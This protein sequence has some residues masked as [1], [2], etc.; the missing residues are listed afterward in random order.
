MKK[1]R[2]LMLADSRAF[3]TERLVPE[4]RRQGCAAF[5]ASMENGLCHHFHLRRR[6]PLRQL[7][8]RL[9]ARQVQEIIRRWRP[10]IINPHFASGY[11]HLAAVANRTFG[12]PIVLNLWGS[13]ILI[14]PNKSPLHKKKVELAL[15]AADHTL[16][17]SQYM[18]EVAR[19]L[20]PLVATSVIPWG[21]ERRYLGQF[22]LPTDIATPLRIIVPRQHAAVYNNHLVAEALA[23]HLIDGKISL[24]MPAFGP[25]VDEFTARFAS[26]LDNGLTLYLRQPRDEFMKLMASHDVYLSA[27]RSDSSPA[28]L[29]E[30][31]ALGLIPVA[32]DIKGVAEWLRAD[33]GLLFEQ[34]SP[35]SLQEAIDSV[36]TRSRPVSQWRAN[37]RARVERGAIFEDNVAQMVGVMTGLVTA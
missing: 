8:Y 4:L 28:S 5:L 23:Q 36:L 25:D 35:E 17:D 15:A 24:T 31:M 19:Q 11:G 2:V 34:D 16:S 21:V 26:L 18:L 3:H 29:I 1:L 14:V 7:H 37:N 32:A 30:A 12:L 9:A 20:H 33:N 13:D 10:D 27:S 22:S 6:G